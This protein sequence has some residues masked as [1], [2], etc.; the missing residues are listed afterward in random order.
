MIF[1]TKL[2]SINIG[3]CRAVLCRDGKPVALTVD[4]KPVIM[5]FIVL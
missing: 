3:D 2:I 4:H 1:G 5:N